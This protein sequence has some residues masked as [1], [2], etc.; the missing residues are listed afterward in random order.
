MVV[1]LM[2]GT[3]L[4]INYLIDPLWAYGGNKLGPHNYAYNE[5]HA[6]T[7]LFL[8]NPS[9]Y[10]CLVLGSSTAS[11]LDRSRIK[12]Y[13]CF[14]YSIS[15]GSPPEF[16][17]IAEYVLHYGLKPKLVIIGVD[18]RVFS[19]RKFKNR[20]PGFIKNKIDPPKPL[21]LLLSLNTLRLSLKSLLHQSPF[22][23]Y[24]TQDFI[25][26]VLAGTPAFK[27]QRCFSNAFYGQAF[28]LD[29]A[30]YFK[31]LKTM[32]PEARLVGYVPPI[33]A[34]DMATIAEDKTLNSYLNTMHTVA[35]QF[36]LFFDFS[37]PSEITANPSL[38][39]DGHHF[40]R[41]TNDK[42]ADFINGTPR[43]F[44]VELTGLSRDKYI[45]EFSINMQKFVS[46][47]PKKI[48]FSDQ[49]TRISHVR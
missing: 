17:Q 5:R 26:D 8:K 29:N 49:C 9:Q 27:P 20:T 30:H 40:S 23:R 46:S 36:D 22:P 32:F 47:L 48:L 45:S 24:Y 14:N 18:S 41:P 1:A 28:N 38:S 34:W 37:I 16:V 6:K 4:L 39:F 31:T 19:R 42:I 7:N 10:D 3:T 12:N 33:S 15:A 21:T 13:T 43:S 44:G 2:L 35:Q 11:L 25:G